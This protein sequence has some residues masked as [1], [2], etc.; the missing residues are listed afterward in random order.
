MSNESLAEVMRGHAADAI[1]SV[2]VFI[3]LD[4]SVDS[5]RVTEQLLELGRNGIE[6][7]DTALRT[8]ATIW[9][10]YVG[11][12][13]RRRWGGEWLFPEEGPFRNKVCLV[14]HD[15]KDPSAVREITLFPIDRVYKQLANGIEDGIWSYAC[16]VEARLATK[17]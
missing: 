15:M 3:E 2:H 11:E 5:L 7:S 16:A 17:P 1:A 13:L 6:Q 10:A 9:G 8:L 14:I 4:F 12:V